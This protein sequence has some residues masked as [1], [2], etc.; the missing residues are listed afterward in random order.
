[1]RIFLI[2][3]CFFMVLGFQASAQFAPEQLQIQFGY[4]LHNTGANR[5]NHL[6]NAYNN[7]RYPA[8]IRE[9]LP[10]LNFLH[11]FAFGAA[12]EL[13]DDLLPYIVLK[14]KHQLLESY[15]LETASYR[16]YRF[17]EHTAELGLNMN[18]PGAVDKK[19]RQSAGGGV[20]FGVLS[21]HTGTKAETGAGA[22]QDP[23]RIDQ[24]GLMG[25]TLNY[26]AEY[27]LTNFLALY[28]RP[29]LQ[30]SLPTEVRNLNAFLNPVVEDQVVKY[31]AA[32]DPKYNRGSLN[33]VGIEGGL[34]LLV[35]E[36]NF[37]K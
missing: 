15:S 34:I 1:M 17:R 20:L 22:I 23:V 21:V 27:H 11:G 3:G 37:G 2:I 9:N 14:N 33:G 7:E 12:Y 32:E 8:R 16:Y 31:R 18:L 5:F 30:V 36:I 19:F 13:N 10:S 26:R 24:A 4:H 29:V 25:L 35:P 6:I 28:A